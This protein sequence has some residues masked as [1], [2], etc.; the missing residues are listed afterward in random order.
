MI[1]LNRKVQ[2]RNQLR[3]GRNWTEK[4]ER[5][6]YLYCYQSNLSQHDYYRKLISSVLFSLHQSATH[7]SHWAAP[8]QI[9]RIKKHYF[10]YDK[11]S[12]N[13][14]NASDWE[15]AAAMIRRGISVHPLLFKCNITLGFLPASFLC[16]YVCMGI[17]VWL[18]ALFQD[19]WRFQ[20]ALNWTF[21]RWKWFL[22][23]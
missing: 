2:H 19:V 10:S 20:K 14:S 7:Q 4:F 8:L 13:S 1:D 12:G 11:Q 16:V 15:P 6:C 18:G 3:T 22:F 17:M 23:N 9:A 5:A 21:L